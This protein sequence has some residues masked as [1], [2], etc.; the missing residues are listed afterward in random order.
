M[1]W[2]GVEW[3]GFPVD[4]AGKFWEKPIG[5]LW[6]SLWTVIAVTTGVIQADW[7]V[8]F[9]GLTIASQEKDSIADKQHTKSP[10]LTQPLR[11]PR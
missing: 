3:R 4:G 11:R 10:P 1:A 2:K 7:T 5:V 9:H 8:G 6:K